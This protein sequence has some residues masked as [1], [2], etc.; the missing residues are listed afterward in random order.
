MAVTSTKLCGLISISIIFYLKKHGCLSCSFNFFKAMSIQLYKA[1]A[2]NSISGLYP[3]SVT[4]TGRVISLIL[5]PLITSWLQG[6]K[7]PGL[8]EPL[9]ERLG[10][11]IA[12]LDLDTK[13][14]LHLIP[15]SS[16]KPLRKW[17][18]VHFQ[19]NRN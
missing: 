12:F 10:L 16:L 6:C 8:V 2:M 14:S 9:Q 4:G 18:S 5:A 19:K 17:V 1:A 7:H 15:G 13:E 3:D 11:E